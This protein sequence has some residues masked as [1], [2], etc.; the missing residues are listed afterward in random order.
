MV[1]VR[2]VFLGL[3]VETCNNKVWRL[4]LMVKY[5]LVRWFDLLVVLLPS[6]NTLQIAQ[7]QHEAGRAILTFRKD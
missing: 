2:I 4:A 6:P 7:H 1:P 3:E 5:L